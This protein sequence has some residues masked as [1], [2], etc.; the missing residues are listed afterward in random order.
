MTTKAKKSRENY[1]RL[2]REFELRWPAYKAWSY[3]ME[4]PY[5]MTYSSDRRVDGFS[6]LT[7]TF[8]P[9]WETKHGCTIAVMDAAGRNVESVDYDIASLDRLTAQQLFESVKPMLDQFNGRAAR[10]TKRANG[11]E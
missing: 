6:A 9:C 2:D 11:G 1:D 3:A 10:T 7:V 4:H 8:T 5:V